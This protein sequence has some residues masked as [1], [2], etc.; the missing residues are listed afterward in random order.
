[1]GQIYL[2]KLMIRERTPVIFKTENRKQQ[3]GLIG[4]D[5]KSPDGW[6]RQTKFGIQVSALAYTGRAGRFVLVYFSSEYNVDICGVSNN[7][8]HSN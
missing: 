3:L 4:F 7:Q 1:M 2:L 8:W 6:E 5:Q